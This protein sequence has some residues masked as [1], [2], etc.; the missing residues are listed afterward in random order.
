MLKS[1][2]IVNTQNS[3]TNEYQDNY[4]PSNQ[5]KMFLMHYKDNKSLRFLGGEEKEYYSPHN[6]PQ[7]IP[8]KVYIY[9]YIYMSI[10][11]SCR[12]RRSYL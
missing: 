1:G 2:G 6:F 8:D 3:T 11:R 9:I 5:Q 12:E 10:A 4:Y 7:E